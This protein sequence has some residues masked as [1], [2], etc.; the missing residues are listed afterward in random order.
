MHNRR[1]FFQLTSSAL[2]V[3]S[4]PSLSLA[5][6]D[7]GIEFDRYLDLSDP[8]DFI[9]SQLLVPM[10]RVY[11]NT[12]SMGPSPRSVITAVQNA[13]E[14]LEANPASENWGELGEKMELVRAK[15][16]EFINA[17]AEDIIL[18]RNTTEGLSLIGQ[19]IH[20]EQ[21]DEILTTTREHKGGEVG[22]EYMAKRDG[23]KI[24]KIEL[25][26]PARSVTE[27]LKTI[28]NSLTDKT[29]ILML[30]HV[31]TITG[32]KMPVE[33]ISDLIRDKN[34]WLIVDGAQAPG[35]VDIDL[36][37]LGV[38]AYA[39]SGHKWLL[40]PKETGFLYLS[41]NFQNNFN[42]VFTSYGYTSYSA[43][44][45]TRNVAQFIGLGKSIDIHK[46]LGTSVIEKRCLELAAYCRSKL[47]Q[48][49]NISII[50]PSIVALQTG[51]VSIKLEK[52]N[53]AA[54]AGI[55]KEK[56]IIVKT[57]SGINA[58]RFSCHMF[59]SKEDIDRLVSEL[60]IILA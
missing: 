33:E 44:S 42:P 52:K 25:P 55:L 23:A 24:R 57:L 54:V 53:N 59:I 21:G 43:S 14:Q 35:L 2:G 10:D 38:H 34:I 47:S 31:N 50:S 32:M 18:T 6:V 45:G 49:Q 36:K 26:L 20:L 3:I 16:G 46:E 9:R 41:K 7:K 40:G 51:I 19:S 17:P 15:I 13:I 37:K 39:S 30:S 56:D 48:I 29:K 8:F 1:K 58:L 27:I 4:L 28:E 5:S 12:G 60:I 11:M 22:F